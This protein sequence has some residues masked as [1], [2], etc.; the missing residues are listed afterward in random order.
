MYFNVKRWFLSSVIGF[1]FILGYEYVVHGVL[2]TDLYEQTPE[3][4]RNEAEMELTQPYMFVLQYMMA[5]A[6][7][8]IFT[9]NYEERGLGE[10]WRF[11]VI[12][13]VVFAL[14]AAAPYAW[15]P[16]SPDLTLYSAVA[17]FIKI[18]A[19]GFIFAL[20]YRPETYQRDKK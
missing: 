7:S 10:G 5:A 8:Y 16:I 11:G 3:V 17:A 14:E 19:L 1:L 18:L 6:L 12:F 15:L 2:L 4:W 20:A 13:G 9:L